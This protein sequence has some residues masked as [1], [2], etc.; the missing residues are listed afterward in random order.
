MPTVSSVVWT[1][2][3]ILSVST[4]CWQPELHAA[5]LTLRLIFP[6]LCFLRFSVDTTDIP[7][8]VSRYSA[9]VYVV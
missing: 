5:Q 8:S 7:H 9:H 3:T 6:T 4:S 2:I 1:S